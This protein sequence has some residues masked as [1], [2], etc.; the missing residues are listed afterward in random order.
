[1]ADGVDT[2]KGSV[3]AGGVCS[4]D[5]D[6]GGDVTAGL[7]GDTKAAMDEVDGGLVITG[8]GSRSFPTCGVAASSSSSA[9]GGICLNPTGERG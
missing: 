8:A 3:L 6:E 2:M 4:R 7:V 9:K 5:G 1:M